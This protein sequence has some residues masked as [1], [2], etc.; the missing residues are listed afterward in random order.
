MKE[1]RKRVSDLETGD[2][3]KGF[4]KVIMGAG[5]RYAHGEWRRVIRDGYEHVWP[6]DAEVTV[7]VPEKRWRRIITEET[8]DPT[9]AAGWEAD[10]A[11]NVLLS[12]VT[13]EEIIE[14]EDWFNG[15]VEK[16]KGSPP[17]NPTHVSVRDGS[18]VRYVG[19]ITGRPEL[20]LIE[21]EDGEMW[22]DRR[23]AWSPINP[24]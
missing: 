14:G 4:G 12:S 23:D 22:S 19:E 20:M 11:N 7:L 21:N 16:I 5:N 10:A 18:P 3:V 17:W 13:V 8:C 2:E 15:A 1:I 6:A 9:V 24:S